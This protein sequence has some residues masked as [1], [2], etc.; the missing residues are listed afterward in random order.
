LFLCDSFGRYE[1]HKSREGLAKSEHSEGFGASHRERSE[2]G[3]KCTL[4][5]LL[6]SMLDD[7]AQL[8]ASVNRSSLSREQISSAESVVSSPSADVVAKG[9]LSKQLQGFNPHADR[10]FIFGGKRP[11]L[12]EEFE[13]MRHVPE[14]ERSD[15][16]VSVARHALN[17]RELRPVLI[18][19]LRQL[20]YFLNQDQ[21]IEVITNLAKE[22]S[23]HAACTAIAY[24]LIGSE[25]RRNILSILKKLSDGGVVLR[26]QHAL[27]ETCAIASLGAQLLRVRFPKL[28]SKY[29]SHPKMIRD[30]RDAVR[31]ALDDSIDVIL[32]SE[33]KKTKAGA[34]FLKNLKLTIKDFEARY[35]DASSFAEKREAV[36][37]TIIRVRLENRFFKRLSESGLLSHG[38]PRHWK[39]DELK[40]MEKVLC[41]LP[42]TAVIYTPRLQLFQRV[43]GFSEARHKDDPAVYSRES[44][45]QLTDEVFRRDR[46]GRMKKAAFYIA[47]EIGHALADI[48]LGSKNEYRSN[49]KTPQYVGYLYPREFLA[50]SGWQEV[51]SRYQIQ[52][53]TVKIAGHPPLSLGV[54]H[55]IDGEV[56]EYRFNDYD[57]KL[58][59]HSAAAPFPQGEY[60]RTNPDE[61]WA[62]TFANYVASPHALISHQALGR[63]WHMESLFRMHDRATNLLERAR[64]YESSTARATRAHSIKEQ[65]P[66]S[67]WANAF[68]KL[69]IINKAWVLLG[70]ENHFDDDHALR[71]DTFRD[72]MKRSSKDIERRFERAL[73]RAP[74]RARESLIAE[75]GQYRPAALRAL[76]A[77]QHGHR[78]VVFA[79]RSDGVGR[80]RAQDPLRAELA[81]FLGEHFDPC[82][83]Y[84]LSDNDKTRRLQQP[85]PLKR[86]GVLLSEFCSGTSIRPDGTTKTLA[87]IPQHVYYYDISAE[88]ISWCAE[89]LSQQGLLSKITFINVSNESS[90]ELARRYVQGYSVNRRDELHIF[91]CDGCLVS[92]GAKY[93]II[94]KD[95]G[96]KVNTVT[97]AQFATKPTVSYWLEREVTQRMPKNSKHSHTIKHARYVWDESEFNNVSAV[98][99]HV[100][101]GREQHRMFK[102]GYGE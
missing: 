43:F 102:T 75:W 4:E 66:R 23:M 27:D 34:R 3:E 31:A 37:A 54:A 48:L 81:L 35:R 14:V 15:F 8:S 26:S 20:S 29:A 10:S 44:G 65:A 85:T 101:E 6:P 50:L 53:E 18:P 55:L 47:H 38:Q 39:V 33:W 89:R 42:E 59:V 76:I 67:G 13:L 28:C 30:R 96:E 91:A 1:D 60:S 7:S 80:T 78:V 46:Y 16:V 79:D 70:A 71:R 5:S 98:L 92:L 22:K 36:N 63:F 24:V 11:T 19:A 99:A 9:W 88:R 83:L 57:T 17:H 94:D 25:S 2:L 100:T 84:L 90:E 49:W 86:A 64:D 12:L 93:G 77:L 95:T 68:L 41:A 51:R 72:L 52:G 40:V 45:I 82:R 62:E 97:A 32:K 74:R 87:Q 61:D 56:R 58:Y 69:P 21:R 73:Q